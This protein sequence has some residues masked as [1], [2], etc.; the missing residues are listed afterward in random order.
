VEREERVNITSLTCPRCQ[1]KME[2]MVNGGSL[3]LRCTNEAPRCGIVWPAE[4]ARCAEVEERV[5]QNGGR[6]YSFG[7]RAI[8]PPITVPD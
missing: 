3:W 5:G 7:A 4:T 2:P 8:E 1:R 6:T